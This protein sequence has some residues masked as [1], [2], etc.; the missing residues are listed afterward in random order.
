MEKP[1]DSRESVLSDIQISREELK[2]LGFDYE[3]NESQE[4]QYEF[5]CIPSHNEQSYYA[6]IFKRKDEYYL[7]YARPVITDNVYGTVI[8]MRTFSQVVEANEKSRY[9]GK[10]V[11]GYIK[12][13]KSLVDYIKNLCSYIAPGSHWNEDSSL[14]IDG[15]FQMI[16]EYSSGEMQKEV[17]FHNELKSVIDD[18]IRKKIAELNSVIVNLAF[19]GSYTVY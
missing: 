18:N 11:C 17:A 5:Y 14:C 4:L 8:N 15:T 10:I 19:R 13:D 7:A 2:K 9:S 16:C 12:T 6:Q 3:S 1:F